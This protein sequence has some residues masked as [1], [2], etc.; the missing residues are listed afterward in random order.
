MYSTPGYYTTDK[1]YSV[2][3]TVYSVNPDELIWT[4]TTASVN[5]ANLQRTIDDV[6]DVITYDMKKSGF[7]K[8]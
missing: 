6:A 1:I 7:L 5:P 8:E 2:E 4:G 3:T